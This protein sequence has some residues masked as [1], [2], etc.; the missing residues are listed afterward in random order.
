MG[1]GHVGIGGSAEKSAALSV[2][3]IETPW[4][5]EKELGRREEQIK[6]I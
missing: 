1:K 2:A 6:P 4:I 3:P 5:F